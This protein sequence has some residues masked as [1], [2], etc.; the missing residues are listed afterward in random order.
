MKK[1]KKII[2][3]SAIFLCFLVSSF[4]YA[5]Y[6]STES[7]TISLNIS[8]PMYAITLDSQS[9][10]TQGTATIYEKYNVGYYLDNLG[11][12]QMTE[13]TNAITKPT[14]AGYV[15]EGYFTGTNGSGTKYIN[16]SGNITSSASATNF[17]SAGN[18]YAKW[19]NAKAKI[20]NTYYQ[21]LQKALDAVPTDDTQT[22][23]VLLAN[24]QEYLKVLAGQNVLFDLENNTIT[25]NGTN[26]VIDVYGTLT[27]TN[28]T[29][30]TSTTQGAINV[31]SGGKFTISGG[32]I[33]AT[34][35]R[36]AIYNDGGTTTIT[37]TA[38]LTNVST[39]RAA[40]HNKKGTLSI[41]GGTIISSNFSGLQIDAGNITIGTLGGGVS[42]TT[43]VIQ[44]AGVTTGA[45]YGVYFSVSNTSAKFYDGIIKGTLGTFSDF[46]KISATET[47]YFYS[48]GTEVIS[49]A[50]YD[51]VCLVAGV[52]VTFNANGGTVS[53]TT[54]YVEVGTEIGE[55]PVPRR[56][57]YVFDGWYT[58]PD[59]GTLIDSHYIVNAD[60][61]F[62]AHWTNSNL[63]VT[64]ELNGVQYHLLQDAID[65]VATDDVE[66]TIT[67]LRDTF[68]NLTIAQHKNIVFDIGSYTISEGGSNV[69]VF[70][71]EGR[72][73]FINGTVVSNG[74]GAIIDN[75]PTGTLII[76]GGTFTALYNRG[77]IY[78]EGIVEISG[79]AYL[80][81]KATG[82]PN[83][84]SM[85]RGTIQNLANAT[86]TITG[87]TVVGIHQQAIS[88]LGTMTLGVKLD[89]TI[90]AT[91][92]EIIGKT[93]GIK[94]T[95]T[96]N[97][98]DGIIKGVTAPISG[99][100][101]DEEPN[102]V[103]VTGTEVID[104][105]TYNTRHLVAN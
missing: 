65:A 35:T 69:T 19:V 54:R 71:N 88:N 79:N 59:N 87:G 38:L 66:R 32:T 36:Q 22:T 60:T 28:G 86:L 56:T 2:L 34:G 52:T 27:M 62:Y 76:E 5:R 81:S 74:T 14:K 77:A 98:Y 3:F 26:P 61:P 73:K 4:I 6:S 102:T 84:S 72:I 51:T 45:G 20:G 18:L 9:G 42:T 99:T 97:I 49:G 50:T 1:T 39:E 30:T 53:E 55:L 25:N 100:I 94:S 37:G 12:N 31:K 64:A 24:T 46:D 78:N 7:K 47:G 10:D 105:E 44:G 13:L 48:Y 16:S 90:S 68:E 85:E 63:V 40:V 29:I 70:H 80:S 93:Y 43:P 57:N 83:G 17:N 95:G 15:F 11:T 92:P 75:K 91:T 21:T 8:K 96:L 67:L 82:K 58:D 41:T 104:G 33:N 101:S 103:P 23:V 89:G